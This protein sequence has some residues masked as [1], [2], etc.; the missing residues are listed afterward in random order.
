MHS[1]RSITSKDAA[2]NHYQFFV[3]VGSCSKHQLSLVLNSL[4]WLRTA[5]NFGLINHIPSLEVGFGPHYKTSSYRSL[6]SA[7][8][9]CIACRHYWTM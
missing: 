5:A 4:A 6:N 7:D 9:A 3:L 1:S 2:S 8:S